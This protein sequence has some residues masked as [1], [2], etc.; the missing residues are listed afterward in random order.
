MLYCF[1]NCMKSHVILVLMCL[2]QR[3]RRGMPPTAVLKP[4]FLHFLLNSFHKIVR[5]FRH[6]GAEGTVRYSHF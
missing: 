5:Y 1:N 6:E 2:R 3:C 4:I